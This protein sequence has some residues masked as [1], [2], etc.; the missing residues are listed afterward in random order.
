MDLTR[1]QFLHLCAGAGLGALGLSALAGC[2][3]ADDR[4][5]S[6]PP[7]D[8]PDA[9][10]P[11]DGPTGDGP[12]GDAPPM[13]TCQVPEVEIGFNHDHVMIISALDITAGV[14]KVYDITG[15]SNHPHTVTITA[16][17]F[18]MLQQNIQVTAVS[19][20]DDGH[21]HPVTIRCA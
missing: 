20:V 2:D 3:G 6:G 9:A 10:T 16:P 17:M 1:S 15:T 4:D 8:T 7:T 11:G 5:P 13:G 12:P 19:S 14:E 21:P 18:A